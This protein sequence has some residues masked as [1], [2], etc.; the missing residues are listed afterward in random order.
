MYS[1]KHKQNL[2]TFF[3]IIEGKKLIIF[4]AGYNTIKFLNK[5]PNLNVSYICDNDINKI[6]NKLMGINIKN[7]SSLKNEDLEN[8]VLLIIAD[9]YNEIIEDE[10]IKIID[11]IF[12]LNIF[13]CNFDIENDYFNNHK[14]EINSILDFLSDNMS[15]NIY[16]KI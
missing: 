8:I 15:R 10:Y 11:N 16:K 4:G 7:P 9:R 3:S 14:N 1:F 2:D 6:E 13:E 12:I 5:Y